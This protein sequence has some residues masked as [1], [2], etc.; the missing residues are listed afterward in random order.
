MNLVVARI[1]QFSRTH[2]NA[3]R[4]LLKAY[5]KAS[6]GKFLQ[7]LACRRPNLPKTSFLFFLECFGEFHV[8]LRKISNTF[9][10]TGFLRFRNV[11]RGFVNFK[12]ALF[13]TFARC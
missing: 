8:S 12:Y 9:F 1:S 11:D 13:K 10:Y 7:K 6:K 3:F 4:Y 2:F 5:E